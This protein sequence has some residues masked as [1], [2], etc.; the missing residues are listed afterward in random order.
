MIWDRRY[1]NRPTTIGF[2]QIDLDWAM[3]LPLFPSASGNRDEDDEEDEARGTT[4]DRT[5]IQGVEPLEQRLRSQLPAVEAPANGA[6]S[7]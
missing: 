3:D 4:P 6:R 2:T 7:A 1:T 5:D